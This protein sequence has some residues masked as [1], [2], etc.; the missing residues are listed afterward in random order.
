MHSFAH[1]YFL[2][3]LYKKRIG[4]MRMNNLLLFFA[5][6]V[7]TIIFSIVLQKI[8]NSPLLV[9]AT[10][11]AIFL[12]IT[13][14]VFDESFLV[15]AILYTILSLITALLFRFICCLVQNSN[16]QCLEG[17]NSICSNISNN[18]EN[19]ENDSNN[20]GCCNNNNRSIISNASNQNRYTRRYMFRR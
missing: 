5:I 6:P 12:L 8:L 10:A 7:A 9:S 4:D 19:D 3:I 18:A 16:N 11:F 14:S 2:G 17:L 20:C 1:L 15:F 13:F